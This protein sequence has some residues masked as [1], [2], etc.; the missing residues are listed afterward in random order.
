MWIGEG[1]EVKGMK[2]REWVGA[3]LIEDV[4]DGFLLEDLASRLLLLL[5]EGVE[6]IPG[7]V[8]DLTPHS[9]G[10]CDDESDA[11]PS[12]AAENICST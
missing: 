8:E 12:L 5:L 10:V 11:K 3:C 4:S 2:V 6:V 7:D 1:R 9:I